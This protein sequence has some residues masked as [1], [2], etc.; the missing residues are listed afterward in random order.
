[1]R[2]GVLVYSDDFERNCNYELFDCVGGDAELPFSKVRDIFRGPLNKIL[3]M[4]IKNITISGGVIVI[5][6]IC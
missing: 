3:D 6:A 4:R 1:M 5:E 2:V